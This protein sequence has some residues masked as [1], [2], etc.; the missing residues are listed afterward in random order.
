MTKRSI[1]MCCLLMVLSACQLPGRGDQPALY[2]LVAVTQFEQNLPI[3]KPQLLI[4][5]PTAPNALNSARIALIETPLRLDYYGGV[6]WT[7]PV[8]RC[9]NPC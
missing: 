7:G 9:C 2:R 5:Q 4:E 3:V 6:A 1:F 8:P